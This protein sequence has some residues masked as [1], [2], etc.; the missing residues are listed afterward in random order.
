MPNKEEYRKSLERAEENLSKALNGIAE[1]EPELA[2]VNLRL[3][4]LGERQAELSEQLR[5]HVEKRKFYS[6]KVK[7][8]RDK[9]YGD[10]EP[11]K[12]WAGVDEI[13]ADLLSSC[14][15]EEVAD[16][17]NLLKPCLPAS[18]WDRLELFGTHAQAVTVPEES[19]KPV[20]NRGKKEKKSPPPQYGENGVEVLP[21]TNTLIV[22]SRIKEQSSEFFNG[23]LQAAI[24]MN[25]EEYPLWGGALQPVDLVTGRQ[26]RTKLDR[27]RL[28]YVSAFAKWLEMDGRDVSAPSMFDYLVSTEYTKSGKAITLARPGG[29]RTAVWYRLDDPSGV[30]KEVKS[31]VAP[32]HTYVVY[33]D[34]YGGK[35]IG[36]T[37]GN[38]LNGT[39]CRNIFS[40][41]FG[42]NSGNKYIQSKCRGISFDEIFKDTFLVI[43]E[44]QQQ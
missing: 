20:G 25:G 3:L 1:I 6:G 10:V 19:P 33:E 17:A 36:G 14:S 22:E 24:R 30:V 12:L 38:F 7:K 4:E 26:L 31:S 2:D 35:I 9:L 16:I 43:R 18:D 42:D 5:Q 11:E 34:Q 37:S 15:T 39:F 40:N 44:V 23:N 13:I 29:N 21:L 27:I 41:Y 28:V 32:S 8:I